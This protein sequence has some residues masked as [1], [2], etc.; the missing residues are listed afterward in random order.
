MIEAASAE[1]G[2]H[3]PADS[4]IIG[5]F[6]DQRRASDSPSLLNER[7]GILERIGLWLRSAEPVSGMI[8]GGTI[9]ALRDLALQHD[10]AVI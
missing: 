1:P 6:L 10:H 8:M 5:R 2:R 9:G 4:G 7:P 3:K